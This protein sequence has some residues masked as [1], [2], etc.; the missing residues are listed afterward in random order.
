MSLNISLEIIMTNFLNL[1][2]FTVAV[3]LII[4]GADWFIEAAV[5]IA[6]ATHVPKV[7]IGATYAVYI[8]ILFSVIRP[9]GNG[10]S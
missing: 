3:A 10:F 9:V 8:V 4:K 2:L 6:E 1:V 7:I 5:K